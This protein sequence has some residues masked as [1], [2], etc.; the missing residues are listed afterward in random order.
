MQKVSQEQGIDYMN[1][2]LVY[3]EDRTKGKSIE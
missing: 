3:F 2:S 1:A